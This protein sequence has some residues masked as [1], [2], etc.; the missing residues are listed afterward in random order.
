MTMRRGTPD[1]QDRGWQP[2]EDVDS[3]LALAR[4]DL[5]AIERLPLDGRV[6]RLGGGLVPLDPIAL[7]LCRTPADLQASA[8]VL[9]VCCEP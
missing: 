3:R 7:M 8:K 1:S 4:P 2:A 5:P 6:E 9:L